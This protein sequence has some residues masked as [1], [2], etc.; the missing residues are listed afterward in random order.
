M[1]GTSFEIGTRGTQALGKSTLRWDVALYYARLRDEILS[2]ED[3]AAPGTQLA[4][5]F[6]RTIHAGVEALVGASF[7]LDGIGAHRIEPLLNLTL[8]RFRFSDDREYGNNRLPAAPR[9][10]IRGELLYR[11]V[12]GFFA[13]PTFDIVGKRYADFSNTYT[14]DSYNLWG[15][16]AG[17]EHKD[18]EVFGEIRNLADKKYI[19]RHSVRDVAASDA[20]ILSP[21]EP[22]SVY[23]G[24]RTRF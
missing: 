12:H 9:Y 21:G 7:P 24:V 17:L 18:W 8:N 22:R 1:R 6:D 15:L 23:V 10:A 16:R 3:P 14:V 11:N 5:N 19:A 2:V 4:G 13:G 20:G